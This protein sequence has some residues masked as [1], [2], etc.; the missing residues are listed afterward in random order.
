MNL[1]ERIERGL[2]G[3][4]TG[5]ANG[6][7]RINSIIFGIQRSTYTLLGGQSGCLAKGTKVLMYSGEF[8][9]VEHITEGDQL[10]GPDSMPRT[11]ISLYTGTEDMYWIRQNKGIDY[12][13]NKSHL[14]TLRS[15][16]PTC[17]KKVVPNQLHLPKN[18]RKRVRTVLGFKT[19]IEDITVDECLSNPSILKTWKGFKVGIEFPSKPVLLDPYMLGIWLGDGHSAGSMVTNTDVEIIQFLSDYAASN[20]LIVKNYGKIS[21]RFSGKVKGINSFLQSLRSFNV[22]NNKHIPQ[23][24]LINDKEVR[25]KLL[26]GLIDSDGHKPKKSNAYIFNLSSARLAHDIC[27]CARSLGFYSSIVK[28][29]SSMKRSD[30]SYYHGEIY[31][32]SIYGDDLSVIPVKVARKKCVN[33]NKRVSSMN[34]GI[35][36][37]YSGEEEY[38]GF[39]LSGDGRFLL[40]DFTVTHNT[41]KTTLADFMVLNAL[42]DAQA[43]GIPINIFYYSYEIDALSKKCNWLSS[44]IYRKY[45]KVIP[46]EKIKGLGDFRMSPEEKALVDAEIP[47]VEELFSKIKWNFKAT[48]PTGIYNELWRFMQDRGA[49]TEDSYVDHDGKTKTFKSSWTPNNPDEYNLVVLDH[50]ALLQKERGFDTKQVIDKYSEYCVALRNMFGMSFINISQF[51]DGLSS[52]DRAKFKGIDLSPQQTDFKDTRNP[53]ADADIVLATMAPYKL[54]MT[55]CLGYNVKKLNKHMIML[56]VLKNR[57]SA[58][59][60]AIGLF[61]NPKAMTF[62]ELPLPNDESNMNKVYKFIEQLNAT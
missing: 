3:K 57:L 14:L 16:I 28:S 32:V 47:Y 44:I 54:D 41:Y 36:I 40:E 59:N 12:K 33:I 60:V 27:Y 19:V 53:Y 8:K 13:V 5:L 31:R 55:S 4:Y 29:S 24:Y 39:N 7:N 43:K 22:I 11:V 49:F 34:T 62:K 37:E 25:L 23:D 17:S 20:N 35:K 26:A 1:Q 50:L 21:Y 18:K 52:V 30:G 48:N 51:N 9:N 10:M 56:K 2:E 58:D 42:E 15:T 6:L 38:F 45:G 46:T 61:V